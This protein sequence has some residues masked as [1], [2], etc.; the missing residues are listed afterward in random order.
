MKVIPVRTDEDLDDFLITLETDV[1][2]GS[3]VNGLQMLIA[4][5][6]VRQ[7]AGIDLFEQL[8]D[9][10]GLDALPEPMAAAFGMLVKMLADIEEGNL[11][12]YIDEI[13]KYAGM[14]EHLNNIKQPSLPESE[15]PEKGGEEE[16]ADNTD[17]V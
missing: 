16:P 17:K 12:P 6:G 10:I 11:K 3:V 5:K 15:D 7:V 2:I 9:L 13:K 4:D 8:D 14:A 1:A